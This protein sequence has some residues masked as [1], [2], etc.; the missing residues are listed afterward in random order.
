MASQSSTPASGFTSADNLVLDVIK[1][2]YIG[3]LLLLLSPGSTAGVLASVSMATGS[4]VS[5][6][7]DVTCDVSMRDEED[8]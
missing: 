5:D 4:G 7:G 1:H 6:V 8:T 3:D 2:S